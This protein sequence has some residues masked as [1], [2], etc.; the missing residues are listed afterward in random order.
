MDIMGEAIIFRKS[1]SIATISLIFT[2]GF[3]SMISVEEFGVTGIGRASKTIIVDC[4][5]GGS[6]TTIPEAVN[7][8]SAGDTVRVWAG[9]YFENVIIK[10]SINFIGNHS[11][12]TIIDGGGKKDV[13]YIAADNV[14]VTGFTFIGCGEEYEI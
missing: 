12:S 1:I 13:V 5:G 14:N 3:I 2:M 8:A 6:Y 10:K 11:S 7:A 9:T 4:N